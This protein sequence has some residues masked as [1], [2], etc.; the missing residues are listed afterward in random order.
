M[1]DRCRLAFI[2][3]RF[4]RTLGGIK[5]IFNSLVYIPNN[6]Y[7]NIKRV[8]WPL[9]IF[10]EVMPNSESKFSRCSKMKK[11]SETVHINIILLSVVFSI[12]AKQIEQHDI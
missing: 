7:N 3:L 12:A 1:V 9:A 8:D 5:L 11:M 6:Y 4:P 10:E 2:V